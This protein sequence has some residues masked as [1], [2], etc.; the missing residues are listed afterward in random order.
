MPT[1]PVSFRLDDELVDALDELVALLE[2]RISQLARDGMSYGY[3]RS[4]AVRYAIKWTLE[5]VRRATE[6]AAAAQ[7]ELDAA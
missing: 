6:A 1:T 7:R 4:S 5:D 3:S 2:H